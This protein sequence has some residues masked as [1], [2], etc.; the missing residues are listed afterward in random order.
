MAFA[1]KV[2]RVTMFGSSFGGSEIWTTG[3]YAGNVDSDSAVPNESMAQTVKDAWQTF[4]TATSSVIG[5][6]WQTLGVKVAQLNTDGTTNLDAVVTSYYTTPISGQ[7]AGAGFPPQISVVATLLADNGRGLAG[8]GRM[9]LPG[10]CPG[11]TGTGHLTVGANNTI[12][13]SMSTFFEDIA[14]DFDSPGLLI[15]ASKGRKAPLIG[16]GVSRQVTHIRVGDVYDTQRRRRNQLVESYATS[17]IG[18]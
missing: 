8:K 4:F 5:Y 17:E 14:A 3:F 12:A 13:N 18:A 10:V 9:Y 11:I 2:N 1:H 16:A 6:T 15:N 7:S